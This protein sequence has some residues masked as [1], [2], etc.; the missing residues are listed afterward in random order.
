MVVRATNLLTVMGQGKTTKK[1][2]FRDM[3]TSEK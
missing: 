1:A 3:V 2:S